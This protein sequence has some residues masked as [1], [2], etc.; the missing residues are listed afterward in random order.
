ME[1]KPSRP[2]SSASIARGIGK[3]TEL[4][5]LINAFNASGT[6]TPG[7]RQ[8][9]IASVMR[10]GIPTWKDLGIYARRMGMGF[11]SEKRMTQNEVWRLVL[12]QAKA[13]GI[14]GLH[15]DECRH[16]FPQEGRAERG[17]ILDSFKSLLKE[18]E[19][20]M[21]L[22]LSGVEELAEHIKSDGQ[23]DA[24][25]DDVVFS[26]CDVHRSGDVTEINTLCHAYAESVGLIFLAWP[27]WGF[28]QRL[29]FVCAD[30]WGLVIE[31]LINSP[32]LRNTAPSICC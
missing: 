27:P 10:K 30:R 32:F 28:C 16:I 12:V 17:K 15:F 13:Q 14:I 3:T 2:G 24:L 9:K 31:L 7:G 25:L 22:V 1:P 19:W 20:P 11:W 23:L 21:I 26:E 18:Q 8:A 4:R 5:K 29:A 6:V